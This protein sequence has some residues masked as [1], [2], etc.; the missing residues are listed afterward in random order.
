MAVNIMLL[1]LQ[2]FNCQL[3]IEAYAYAYVYVHYVTLW[4]HH[5][6]GEAEGSGALWIGQQT[7][8]GALAVRPPVTETGFWDMERHLSGGEGAGAG[9]RG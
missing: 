1:L 6:Q 7:K 8:A 2:N 9:G 3:E 4:A 5:L